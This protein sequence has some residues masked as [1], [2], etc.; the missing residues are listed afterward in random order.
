[1]IDR[2]EYDGGRSPFFILQYLQSLSYNLQLQLTPVTVTIDPKL[3]HLFCGYYHVRVNVLNMV[4]RFDDL[5][6][7]NGVVGADGIILPSG[8]A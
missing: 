8:R 2:S 7:V 3:V 6:L 5:D 1:M 4:S